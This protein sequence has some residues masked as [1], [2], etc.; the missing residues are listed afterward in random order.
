MPSA[1]GCSSCEE[2][3]DLTEVEYDAGTYWFTCESCGFDNE[4]VEDHTK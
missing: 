4:I 1:I 2:S 3:T